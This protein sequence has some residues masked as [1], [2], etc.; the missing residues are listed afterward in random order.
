LTGCEHPPSVPAPNAR[1]V[2]II[3]GF[4]NLSHRPALGRGIFNRGN[5]ASTA[6]LVT[7][8]SA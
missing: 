3:D 1:H 4:T 7:V 2:T 5:L 8:P 6:S